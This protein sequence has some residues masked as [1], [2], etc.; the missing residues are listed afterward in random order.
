MG[1]GS[2]WLQFSSAVFEFRELSTF[3]IFTSPKLELEYSLPSFSRGLIFS[4]FVNLNEHLTDVRRHC[5][6][7]HRLYKQL[8]QPE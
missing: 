6:M 3:Q 5:Y 2:L 7:P 1:K 8:E 4:F